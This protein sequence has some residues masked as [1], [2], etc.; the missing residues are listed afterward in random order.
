METED[1]YWGTISAINENF[2]N[3]PESIVRQY[4]MLLSGGMWG[5]IELTYDESEIHGKKIRPFKVASSRRSR[6]ASSTWTS[7]SRSGASSP[8]TNG[9]TSWSTPA[10]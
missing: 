8:P 7:S 4:P 10:A 1:K 6:S 3:I 5:T 2:V 9:S